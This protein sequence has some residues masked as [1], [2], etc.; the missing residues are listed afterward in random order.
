MSYAEVVKTA[1]IRIRGPAPV[2]V[3][4][5]ALTCPLL[6]LYTTWNKKNLR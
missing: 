1:A 2:F 4:P 5:L 6:R 3:R